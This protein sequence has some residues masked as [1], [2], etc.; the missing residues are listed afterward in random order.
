V[1][2]AAEH[3]RASSWG[4]QVTRTAGV[5]FPV[6][7]AYLEK[8]PTEDGIH[9][10]RAGQSAKSESV[11]HIKQLPKIATCGIPV[12]L[13]LYLLSFSSSFEML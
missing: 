3:Q 9:Y 1:S 11:V 10:L 6:D 13:H 12:V 4:L 8:P 2:G 7:D 5:I